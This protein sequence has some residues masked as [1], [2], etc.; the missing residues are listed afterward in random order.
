MALRELPLVES[1]VMEGFRFIDIRTDVFL[2]SRARQAIVD[3]ADDIAPR[4]LLCGIQTVD[5]R[6]VQVARTKAWLDS[7]AAFDERAQRVIDPTKLTTELARFEESRAVRHTREIHDGEFKSL[8]FAMEKIGPPA[9]DP[10]FFGAFSFY[11]MHEV[12]PTGPP[13]GGPER[14][15]VRASHIPAFPNASL[16]ELANVSVDV[17]VAFVKRGQ[18]MQL[19]DGRR[20]DIVQISAPLVRQAGRDDTTLIDATIERLE[21]HS[22]RGSTTVTV[23]DDPTQL[24]RQRLRV[25]DP[26]IAAF[27]EP[28]IDA[29]IA[30]RP[31]DPRV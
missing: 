18:T 26:T 10:S 13:P 27:D 17:L 5:R 2:R 15:L 14:I 23:Y 31:R 29:L 21:F 8:T 19:A 9:P 24:G 30:S 1:F 16:E 28:E 12:I 25:T 22:I 6:D 11:Q 3:L 7:G 4:D 20:L